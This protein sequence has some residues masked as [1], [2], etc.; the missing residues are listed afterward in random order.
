ML[1]DGTFGQMVRDPDGLWRFEPDRTSAV[2]R[3]I[4]KSLPRRAFGSRSDLEAAVRGALKAG[5]PAAKVIVEEASD[6]LRRR[7]RRAFGKDFRPR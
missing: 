3:A 5:R 4:A 7:L 2:G 6:D 1:K